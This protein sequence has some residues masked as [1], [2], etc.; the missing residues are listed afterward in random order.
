MPTRYLFFQTNVSFGRGTVPQVTNHRKKKS[1]LPPHHRT[2]LLVIAE[3]ARLSFLWR[4]SFF[5]EGRYSSARVDAKPAHSFF[6]CSPTRIRRRCNG[7]LLEQPQSTSKCMLRTGQF[8]AVE[9]ILR[10]FSPSCV[11][12]AAPAGHTRS[13][14]F[15]DRGSIFPP[16]SFLNDGAV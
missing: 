4:G 14:A 12:T 11:P 8:C 10:S 6:G 1:V 9:S 7:V 5:R 16:K 15:Y 3:N 13:D 2:P